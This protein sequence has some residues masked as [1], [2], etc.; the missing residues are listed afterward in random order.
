MTFHIYIL[1]EK[2]NLKCKLYEYLI[3]ENQN[4]I[5]IFSNHYHLECYDF[6]VTIITAIH[7][8]ESFK[9]EA[10][11]LIDKIKKEKPTWDQLNSRE[12]QVWNWLIINY[13]NSEYYK[14]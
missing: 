2:Q 9:I 7:I 4:M 12:K 5:K 3:Y 1:V 13:L 6:I 11:K 10:V 14:K 8:E